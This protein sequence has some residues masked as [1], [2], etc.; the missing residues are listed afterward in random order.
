MADNDKINYT[1]VDYEPSLKPPTKEAISGVAIPD[2]SKS[3]LPDS[4]NA[5]GLSHHLR[6]LRNRIILQ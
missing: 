4:G 3:T 6:Q 2:A 1:P 5:G